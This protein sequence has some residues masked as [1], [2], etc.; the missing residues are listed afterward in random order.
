RFRETVL[1]LGG[2]KSPLEVFVSFRGREPSPE[3]LLRHNGL[4]PVAAL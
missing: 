4:L 2:G 3:A 1:A